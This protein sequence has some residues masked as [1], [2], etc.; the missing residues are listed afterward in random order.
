MVVFLRTVSVEFTS[1]FLRVGLL[2]FKFFFTVEDL[3]FS[4]VPL[5]KPSDYFVP[6]VLWT[7]PRMTG[8]CYLGIVLLLRIYG[9]F[10]KFYT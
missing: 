10:L 2:S 4:L 7:F 8:D 5:E 3:Y 1:L 9:V 6:Q